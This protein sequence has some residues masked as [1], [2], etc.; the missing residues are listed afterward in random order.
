MG[1]RRLVLDVVLTEAYAKLTYIKNNVLVH[2][3]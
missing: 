2:E 1:Q 3:V